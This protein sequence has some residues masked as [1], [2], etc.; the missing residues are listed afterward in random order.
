MLYPSPNI[1][2]RLL[3]SHE[4]FF[5]HSV[6]RNGIDIYIYTRLIRERLFDQASLLS[7][8]KTSRGSLR[9]GGVGG[10]NSWVN[11]EPLVGSVAVNRESDPVLHFESNEL[12]SLCIEEYIGFR[13]SATTRK[14]GNLDLR[15]FD[16][17]CI[18]FARVFSVTRSI[19][20]RIYPLILVS[21]EIV[22]DY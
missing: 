12:L 19:S 14:P 8:S 21:G 17:Y 3:S 4:Y 13:P 16:W 11:R 5:N 18:K 9:N 15:F 20:R 6:S 10:R 22:L 1:S 2:P 7:H